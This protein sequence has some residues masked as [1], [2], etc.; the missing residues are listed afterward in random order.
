MAHQVRE[1]K[2][3]S[4]D[5]PEALPE[6]WTLGH[7]GEFAFGLVLAGTSVYLVKRYSPFSGTD[8]MV[9]GCLQLLLGFF[10]AVAVRRK[11]RAR[12]DR[13]PN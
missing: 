10:L 6:P 7:F 9:L 8:L 12:E 4:G 13:D 2:S 3:T 5:Q 11:R 1:D